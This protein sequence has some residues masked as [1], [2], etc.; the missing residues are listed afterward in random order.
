MSVEW[1]EITEILRNK[2]VIEIAGPTQLFW[3]NTMLPLYHKFKTIDN[4]NNTQFDVFEN[5][6]DTEHSKIY[7]NIF[8]IDA[9]DLDKVIINKYDVCISSHFIEHVANPIL[10]L[11]KIKN[12]IKDDGYIL[13]ILPNKNVFWDNIRNFTSIEHI[14]NDYNNNIKEDDLTH[15]DENLKTDHPWKHKYGNEKFES[16]CKNNYTT[17]VLHHHCFNEQLVRDI[18]EY[19]GFNTIYC[20]ILHNDPL[21]IVYIGKNINH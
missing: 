11:K 13:S 4:I 3:D 15:L 5:T 20:K 17:R 18:H 12:I 19:V 2:D 21:Q 9:I 10:L 16:I 8:N 7:N 1:D 14:I 6:Y